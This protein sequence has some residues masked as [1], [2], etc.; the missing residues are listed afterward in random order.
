MIHMPHRSVTRFFVPLIDVL[1]LL[2]C[3]FLLMPLAVESKMQDTQ[4]RNAALSDALDSARSEVQRRGTDLAQ[5]EENM[6]DLD[7]VQFYKEENE[8]LR[9]LARMSLQEKTVP[10]V[11][12]IDKTGDIS[13]YD[14]TLPDD[15]ARMAIP[16]ETTA[17]VLFSRHEKEAGAKREV[18][19]TFLL[20]RPRPENWP[21][22][23]HRDKLAKYRKW[24]ARTANSLK[25]TTP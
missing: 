9:Q 12:D 1:L 6:S 15:K 5:Y 22:R 19:Y 20:P 17:R 13:Y 18:Y 2:F 10:H 3:I 8:R 21:T 14:A 25:E 4:D 7:K 23:I 11:I 24:F 16:D